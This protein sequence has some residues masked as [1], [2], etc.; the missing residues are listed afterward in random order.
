MIYSVNTQVRVAVTRGSA[1]D[2]VIIIHNG[3]N[4]E[5]RANKMMYDI[6]CFIDHECLEGDGAVRA[7]SDKFDISIQDSS[8]AVR[9]LCDEKIVTGGDQKKHCPNILQLYDGPYPLSNVTLEVT[10]ACNL[11]C[12]HCYGDFG[13]SRRNFLSLELIDRLMPELD[14]LNTYD[15]GLTGGEFFIHPQY[16]EIFS[17]FERRG[18]AITVFSNGL[19]TDRIERFAKKHAD[20]RFICKISLDGFEQTHNQL[21]GNSASFQQACRTLNILRDMNN[22][23]VKVSVTL[24][25][26]NVREVRSLVDF[27]RREYQTDPTVDLIFPSGCTTEQKTDLVFAPE[28]FDQLRD[29]YPEYFRTAGTQSVVDGKTAL[30]CIGGVNTLTIGADKKVRICNNA[31]DDRFCFGSLDERSLTDLW[32]NP[33]RG[34]QFFRG[35]RCCDVN[36]CKECDYDSKC[37]AVNCRTLAFCYTGND[38]N[39]NPIICYAQ[40]MMSHENAPQ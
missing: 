3:E 2:K 32:L 8:E 9:F 5:Y 33:P 35:E 27:I 26:N 24:G 39:P 18:Y 40:R 17:L 31:S 7:I 30:R 14:R 13:P 11:K 1:D 21:R 20:T 6:V 37:I 10:D 15:V 38:R 12:R 25:K 16:D 22:V 23:E 19:L 4:T 29:L 34:I 28:E 36:M